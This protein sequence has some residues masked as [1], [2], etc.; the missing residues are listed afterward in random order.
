MEVEVDREEVVKLY[1][2]IGAAAAARQVGVSRRTVQRW[3]RAAGIQ[4][5]GWEP[6]HRRKPCPSA[7]AYS[8][9]CR[10]D[11]CKLANREAQR[12]TKQRRV[13]RYRN[14]RR[15]IKHGVS[16]YS[17][18]DCRCEVCRTA[19]S[20]YLKDRR[21]ASRRRALEMIG[22]NPATEYIAAMIAGTAQPQSEA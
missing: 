10:C 9:G 4:S 13:E 16:G 6:V 21:I 7:A 8:H 22:E 2:E 19:W 15:D 1:Q 18:W 20:K 3:A 14:G 5:G 17:N 11:G 12:A